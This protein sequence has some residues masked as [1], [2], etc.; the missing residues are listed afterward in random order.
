MKNQWGSAVI[1]FLIQLMALYTKLHQPEGFLT[2]FCQQLALLLTG[3]NAEQT[4]Q[5]LQE[6]TGFWIAFADFSSSLPA[7]R[8]FEN[9][10][11]GL[12]DLLAPFTTKLA[13]EEQAL[14]N[15]YA[16]LLVVF[17]DAFKLTDTN[18]ERSKFMVSETCQSVILPAF[19][20]MNLL[21]NSSQ[22]AT[23]SKKSKSPK[24]SKQSKSKSLESS[25]KV[26][27]LVATLAVYARLSVIHSHCE[28]LLFK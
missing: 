22:P 10:W 28:S 20:T 16:Q 3:K 1:D 23:P 21:H 5:T 18:A 15:T 13:S 2:L 27:Y 14:F 12:I 25:E 6:H 11:K 9:V 17:L 24:K 7:L 19:N 4:A 26:G 8:T